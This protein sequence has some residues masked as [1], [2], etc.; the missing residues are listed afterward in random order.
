MF[1]LLFPQCF[2]NVLFWAREKAEL[3]SNT[4]TVSF[5]HNANQY[6]YHDTYFFFKPR[7]FE[8]TGSV[9]RSSHMLRNETQKPLADSVD[10]DQTAQNLQ[11]DFRYTLSAN[12]IFAP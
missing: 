8:M 9:R 3:M 5:G 2:T 7:V 1:N 4:I 12:E 10:Q 11:S 6:P